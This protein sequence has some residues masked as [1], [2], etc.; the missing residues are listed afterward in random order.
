VNH[1]KSVPASTAWVVGTFDTKAAELDYLAGLLRAAGLRVV[2][3]DIGTRS[4]P[5]VADIGA[6]DVARH[7]P[8]G[9]ARCLPPLIVAW[10]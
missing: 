3:V 10:P 2:T 9:E 8:V 7:H 1:P 6:R 5:S 4:A